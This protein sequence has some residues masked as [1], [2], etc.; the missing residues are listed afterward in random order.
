MSHPVTAPRTP[1]AAALRP[2]GFPLRHSRYRNYFLF[3]WTSVFMFIAAAELLL[4]LRALGQGEPAWRDYLALLGQPALLVFNL[5]ALGFA[6]Y[7]AGRWSWI[8]RK[9]AVGRVGPVPRNPLPMPLLGI[10]PLLV[11]AVVWIL[12]LMVL[13]GSLA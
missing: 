13:G 9:I 7:F 4:G 1:V 10:L 3:A 12:V 5:V 8:G 6:L 11:F 2:R